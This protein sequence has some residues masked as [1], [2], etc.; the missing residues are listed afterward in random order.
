MQ[1]RLEQV[2]DAPFDWDETET[3]DAAEI[4][5]PDVQALSPVRWRGEIRFADPGYLLSATFSYQQTLTCQRCLEPL[6]DAV[7]QSMTLLLVP[8]AKSP[9]TA[10]H[11]LAEAELGVVEVPE[12]G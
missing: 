9:D 5:N 4:A 8:G 11:G 2:R 7:E 12:D 10:E 1:V 3:V 6:V